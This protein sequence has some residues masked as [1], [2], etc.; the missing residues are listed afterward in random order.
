M[1]VV[2]GRSDERALL[3]GLLADARSGQSGTLVLSGDPGVGKS[4]LLAHAIGLSDGFLVLRATGVESEVD[5]AFAGSH[6][7]LRPV[8]HLV[9]RLT[10]SQAEALRGALGLADHVN[11]DRFLVA[12][13][14]LSLL[15]E[16]AEHDPVLCVIEDA[17][18]LDVPSVETIAFAAR[19]LH[20]EGVVVLA[21]TRG[22]PWPGLDGRRLGGF[23]F[24]DVAALLREQA[25]AV[26]DDVCDH[27]IE[28][29]GGNALA[30]VELAASLNPEQLTGREPLPHPLRFSDRV[31]DA[32]LGRVRS[33]PPES[34]TL[35]LIAAA[36]DTGDPTVVLRA[37]SQ[38]DIGTDALEAAER[39]GIAKVDSGR[40]DFRHPLVRAAVYQAATLTERIAAHQALARALDSD[41]HAERRAWHL[42]AAAIGPDETIARDL[43]HAAHRATR[44][45]GH[46]VAS[47]AYERAAELSAAASD[48][49]RT[50]VAAAQAAFQAGQ[51]DRAADLS[52]R[53]E[54]LVKD[55][56][57]QDEV[58]VLRGR[59]EFAR[60]SSL[61]AQSLLV[62]TAR[63][64]AE[65]DPPGA[66]AVL[67][68]AARAAWN[69]NDLARHAEA[70]DLLTSLRLPPGD[71]LVALVSTTLATRDL[72]AGRIPDAVTRMREGTRAW[73]SLAATDRV[74]GHD[75]ESLSGE[76]GPARVSRDANFGQASLAHAGFT[77]VTADDAADLTLGAS[78][79]AQCRARGL[80]ARLP[81]ALAHL[82][83]TEA[84]AG[85]HSAAA[86]NA[87]EGLRLASDIGQPMA[88][89]SCESV[90]AWLAAV[91]GEQDRCRQLA[92]HAVELSETH[93]LAAIAVV[94]TWALGLL[95]LSLGRSEQ[96]IDRLLEPTHGPLT[97]PTTRLSIVPDVV[98][99]A[100]RARRAD[101]VREPLA[102]YEQW[103]RCTGQPWAEAAV[104]RC[105]ALLGE[106]DAEMHFEE[107]LR[108]HEQA[109]PAH[110]PFDRARTQLL[111][112]EWLRRARRRA[113]ARPH[114]TAARETFER[115][116]ATPWSDRAANE[117]RATG[118]TI[119]RRRTASIR[120]TPQE[121][122]VVRLVAD[123]GTNQDV[124][125]QLFISPRTVAYHLYN[126]FPKLGVASR[127][128]IAHL[129]LEELISTD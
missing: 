72:V 16:A 38:L 98:E 93:Q 9:D 75:S 125:A 69:A 63:G 10:G 20:A 119:S 81:Y 51:L 95:E 57:A 120:L 129:D 14:T 118:Q 117:L 106:H 41:E 37:A 79:V 116:G 126:A 113:E 108:L 22:D 114:L 71:P 94:A 86:V 8:L 26:A 112:G 89:C 21:A 31:E 68:E 48:R 11:Y 17:H 103:A 92:G 78:M 96:A 110:R 58:A 109:G 124:A 33:L 1:R 29:T 62:N 32:F 39:A 122:Q 70:T 115:L 90:L 55:R 59:I 87:T 111:F 15:S 13:A 73:L 82:A 128:D 42:A 49:A 66:A 12:V 35:L 60:G 67:V 18:W 40:I 2:I 107:A 7:L 64:M 52:D 65:R 28:E 61:T 46:A 88:V 97:N 47:A 27:L 76:A 101:L 105:N 34:R 123:G 121:A 36:D 24:D 19:R 102:W 85:R 30:L 43:E 83:M 91:R 53:A 3:E 6:E 84:L 44:Q 77:R 80:A 45:G 74:S 100:T 4:E 50:T 56:A 99:A 54:L 23:A 25:G 104:H 127:A 5:L